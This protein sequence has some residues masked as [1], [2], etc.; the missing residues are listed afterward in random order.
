MSLG[1]L[2]LL[3]TLGIALAV[4]VAFYA[5]LESSRASILARSDTLREQAAHQIDDQIAAE[6]GV[7]ATTLGAIERAMRAG[8]LDASSPDAVEARLFT[9]ILD[10]PTLSDVTVTRARLTGVYDDG[11][12]AQVDPD[13]RW[14]ISVFR[15]TA[16]PASPVFTRKVSL[17]DGAWTTQVRRR[18]PGAGLLS[19]PFLGEPP[20][21]DP[22]EH[23]TFTGATSRKSYGKAIW[24]DL[25]GPSSTTRCPRSNVASS[26]RCRRPS[27]TRLA[28]SQAWCGWAC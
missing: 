21:T 18:A 12:R 28:T 24:S 6:L 25:R 3:G 22:T 2:F 9:E 14:Q 26:C 23:D 27:T 8:A 16:D 20:T 17:H 13:G 7:A 19:A 5:L 10:H 15:A 11:G 4:G 1:R